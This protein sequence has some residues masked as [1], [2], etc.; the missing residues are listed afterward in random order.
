MSTTGGTTRD[1]VADT[2]GLGGGQKYQRGK[3]VLDD[4]AGEPD[5]D[6]LMQH[7]DAG[8]WDLKDARAELHRQIRHRLPGPLR[9]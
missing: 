6:Q 7:I 9:I 4:L 5:G 1:A 2:V 3:R 8:D